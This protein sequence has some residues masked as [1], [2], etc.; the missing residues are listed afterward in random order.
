MNA[1]RSGPNVRVTPQT[2][3]SLLMPHAGGGYDVSRLAAG[4]DLHG[5][6]VQ[7]FGRGLGGLVDRKV[8]GDFFL[9]F[10]SLS[11]FYI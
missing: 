4:G 9:I 7:A 2:A 5:G 8:S 11:F 6:S 1:A 3:V 10:I